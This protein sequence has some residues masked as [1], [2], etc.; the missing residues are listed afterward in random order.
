MRER[1]AAGT[2]SDIMKT[3][4]RANPLWRLRIGWRPFAALL[5]LLAAQ[6]ACRQRMTPNPAAARLTP[7]IQGAASDRAALIAFYNAAAGPNWHNRDNWLTDAPLARWHGIET[8]P[9]GRV[10]TLAL[11]GNGLQGAVP[12][13]LG[14]LAS[15]TVL[16][17][18]SNGFSGPIPPELGNLRN[19]EQLYLPFMQLSGPLPPQLGNLTNLRRMHIDF[20]MLSTLR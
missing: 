11:H 1:G 12:P 7:D 17:L 9:S 5:L 18:G 3:A 2:W 14:R 20:N 8:G 10:T 15:L 19:L 16:D 6:I 13:E 4:S